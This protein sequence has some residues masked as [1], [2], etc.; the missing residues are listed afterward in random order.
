MTRCLSGA[1]ATHERHHPQCKCSRDLE[2]G[3]GPSKDG[4]GAQQSD[5][6]ATGTVSLENLG[7]PY[8][9]SAR[10]LQRPVMAHSLQH[11]CSHKAAVKTARGLMAAWGKKR[12]QQSILWASSCASTAAV[13]LRSQQEQRLSP[14]ESTTTPGLAGKIN[15]RLALCIIFRPSRE[16]VK[17]RSTQMKYRFY[18][19]NHAVVAR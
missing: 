3:A 9:R 8:N 2:H 17:L 4:C 15:C 1:C 11:L 19:N 6:R 10:T 13:M 16:C 18:H 14:A 7:L 5:G 12:W